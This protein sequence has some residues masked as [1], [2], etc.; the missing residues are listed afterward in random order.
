[1]SQCILNIYTNI[2]NKTFK[3]SII[4]NNI[5]ILNSISYGFKVKDGLN[6]L[7][8]LF[9]AFRSSIFYYYKGSILIYTFTLYFKIIAIGKGFSNNFFYNFNKLLKEDITFYPLQSLLYR[10]TLFYRLSIAAL[11]LIIGLFIKAL[12]LNIKLKERL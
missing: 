8:Y 1:M 2:N 3:D 12:F 10:F 11:S 9:I 7:N 6:I 4:G 5:A